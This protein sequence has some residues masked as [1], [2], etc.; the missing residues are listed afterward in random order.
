[1]NLKPDLQEAQQ[2]SVRWW[3]VM[4]TLWPN[5]N[6]LQIIIDSDM[7]SC[8]CQFTSFL[9]GCH[10]LHFHLLHNH[11][12]LRSHYMLQF[13]YFQLLLIVSNCA[14]DQAMNL[15]NY[16][17]ND[18]RRRGRDHIPES[19][20]ICNIP[21]LGQSVTKTIH[22]QTDF[23]CA[24]CKSGLKFIHFYVLPESLSSDGK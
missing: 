21:T 18:A 16:C 17:K 11:C 1:M 7:W 5:V 13:W 15:K 24:S 23:C 19:I 20:I 3:I 14:W 6:M 9:Q 4:L 8:V 12:S 22:H 2:K 10:I